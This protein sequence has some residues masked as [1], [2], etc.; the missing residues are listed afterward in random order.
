MTVGLESASGYFII[1]WHGVETER[2]RLSNSK[3]EVC[4]RS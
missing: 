2:G 1:A 3:N 4:L